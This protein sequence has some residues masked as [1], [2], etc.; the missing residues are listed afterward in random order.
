MRRPHN[1]PE[2]TDGR[3]DWDNALAA[4]LEGATVLVGM[5]YN[6]PT[7]ERLEQFFGTVM[8]TN[9][10]KGITLRLAGNRAGELYTLPPD[11]RAFSLAP[12]GSYRLRDTGE[13]VVDP[14]YTSTWSFWPPAN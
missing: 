3:P 12:P 10:D 6:E 13:V 5:T 8:E 9:P 2:D 4:R 14:D 11:L 7:G 1:P